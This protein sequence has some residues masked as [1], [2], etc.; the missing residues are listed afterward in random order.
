MSIHESPTLATLCRPAGGDTRRPPPGAGRKHEL[1]QEEV[2]AQMLQRHAG[3]RILVVD[4]NPVDRVRLGELLAA[5][6]FDI[7][8]AVD[9]ADAVT[10]SSDRPPELILMS[11]WMPVMDGLTA[12]RVLRQLPFARQVP[13]V[14][15]SDGALDDE[16]ARF[17][18]AGMDDV[19]A[20]PFVADALHR[21]LLRWLDRRLAF[22]SSPGWSSRPAARA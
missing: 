9:G 5:A 22:G 15:M 14:A 19:V 3:S 21:C 11:S 8:F 16:Y 2:L 4:S 17:L 1:W 7:E 18:V 13:I 20:K 6:C 12:A 10:Q